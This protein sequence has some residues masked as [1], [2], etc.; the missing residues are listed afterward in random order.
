MSLRGLGRTQTLAAAS[1]KDPPAA[2]NAAST[3]TWRA[4][5]VRASAPR[6][7]RSFTPAASP[8]PAT[9]PDLRSGS[10]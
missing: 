2:T 5:G 6:R 4:V 10:C 9:H 1:A 8:R 3:S 7:Y